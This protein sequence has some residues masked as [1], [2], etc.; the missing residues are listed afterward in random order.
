MI[1]LENLSRLFNYMQRDEAKEKK[2]AFFLCVCVVYTHTTQ[3]TEE[4]LEHET[5][6][7]RHYSV[8]TFKCNGFVL[9]AAI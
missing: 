1:S 8:C 2:R 3:K 7:K 9:S 4:N 5:R 6:K